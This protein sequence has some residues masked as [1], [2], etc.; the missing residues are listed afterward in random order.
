M[1]WRTL[2]ETC[3]S[4][5]NYL[6]ALEKR[7]VGRHVVYEGDTYKVVGVDYN[8]FLLIDKKAELTDTTAIDALT[9]CVAE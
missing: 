3:Q 5:Q 4:H 7:W 9:A 2:S 6:V 8:G 1:R